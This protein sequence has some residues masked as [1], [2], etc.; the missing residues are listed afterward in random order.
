MGRCEADRAPTHG[1]KRRCSPAATSDASEGSRSCN[2]EGSVLQTSNRDAGT[3]DSRRY[4]G[5]VKSYNGCRILLEP[6]MLAAMP[7]PKAATVAGDAGSSV[8]RS[9]DGY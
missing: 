9:C 8:A 4:N 3:N 2:G 1:A 5:G 7:P 6:A